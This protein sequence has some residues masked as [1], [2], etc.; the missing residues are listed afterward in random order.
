MPNKPYAIEWLEKA[1]H[2]LGS[3]V[4]LF[5]ADHFTDTI[6]ID[7]HYALEKTLKAILA[8]NNQPIPKTHDLPKL[9]SYLYHIVPLQEEEE[10]LLYIANKYHIEE[11]YPIFQKSLPSK[12]EIKTILIFSQD[13][14][15]KVAT[16]LEIQKFKDIKIFDATTL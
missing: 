7:L 4:I 8:Y 5:K 13:L 12:E 6:G 16:S 9:Y 1:Y 10:A 11:A 15:H 3:A 2:D 14:L